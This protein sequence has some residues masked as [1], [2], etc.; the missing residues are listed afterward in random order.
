MDVLK[1][2]LSMI[3]EVIPAGS[4]IM[5]VDYPV[6]FNVGDLLI[7]MGTEAFFA[8][9]KYSVVAKYSVHG[10]PIKR[11]SKPFFPT[12]P[13]LEK[14]VVVVLHGGGN[15]GDLYPWHQYIRELL[16]KTYPGNRIV[17]LPQTIHFE[18]DEHL[19]RAAKVFQQ[20]GD[21]HLY[22]RDTHS[23]MVAQV[24][25]G[26]GNVRLCP[27]MAHFLWNLYPNTGGHGKG[28]LWLM[29]RDIERVDLPLSLATLNHAP[30]DWADLITPEDEK[31]RL[32]VIRMERFNKFWGLRFLPSNRHWLACSQQV[33][34]RAIQLFQSHDK[35]ITSRLHGHIFASLLGIENV[36]LDNSYGKNSAY[37][38]AWTHRVSYSS[39]CL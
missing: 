37:Y 10:V 7:M 19:Q 20:H 8:D 38:N 1:K 31:Q 34:D 28:E 39:L 6:H 32:K 5:Y 9:R 27:D 17:V 30:M 22:V 29:R 36:L 4:R 14:D 23:L 2:E 24:Q 11:R 13:K 15:L 35:V 33:V 25:M 18:S 16:V 12:L 3:D 26:L 21:L